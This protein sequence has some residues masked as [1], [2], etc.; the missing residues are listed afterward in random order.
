M[1]YR[2]LWTV[3]H[4]VRLAAEWRA[5]TALSHQKAL[6]SK[7][8]DILRRS[9][10][11]GCSFAALEFLHRS[12]IERRPTE[13][14]ECGSGISTIILGYAAHE[15]SSRDIDCR[16][17]SMEEDRVYF[18]DLQ[19][20]MPDEIRKYVDL[21]LSPTEDR[22]AGKGIGRFYAAKPMHAYDLIFVDGPRLPEANSDDRY[23]DGDILDAIDWNNG[24][25]TA[26][27][28]RREHVAR[29]VQTTLP[30]ATVRYD[31]PLIAIDIPAK[32]QRLTGRDI[33]AR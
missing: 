21:R 19:R 20:I 14:L 27:V 11:R 10:S 24:P 17:T 33:A 30:N 31:Q 28:D 8:P 12:V 6:W 1:K 16:V 2:A 15:L 32:S 5:R 7:F 3:W 23:F 18:D 26:L 9:K 4:P 13:I 22:A 29:M 25:I